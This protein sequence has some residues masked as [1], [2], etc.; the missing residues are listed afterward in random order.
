MERKDTNTPVTG[1]STGVFGLLSIKDLIA[2]LSVAVSM[3]LAW[4]VFSTRITLLEHQLVTLKSEIVT[5]STDLRESQKKD[6]CNRT[7]TVR[8]PV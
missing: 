4:G 3:A 1:N 8:E 5:V 2:I 6:C 7:S